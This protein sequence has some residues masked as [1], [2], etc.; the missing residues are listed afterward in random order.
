MFACGGQG[1]CANGGQAREDIYSGAAWSLQGQ[2]GC[3]LHGHESTLHGLHSA[4]DFA[5]ELL[6]EAFGLGVECYYLTVEHF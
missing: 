5:F 6:L 1:Y 4:H 3:F 2:A